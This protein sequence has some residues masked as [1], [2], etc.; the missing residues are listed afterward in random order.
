[1]TVV[2]NIKT[3]MEGK[4]KLLQ[5]DL[6]EHLLGRTSLSANG[7]VRLFNHVGFCALN[8]FPPSKGFYSEGLHFKKMHLFYEFLLKFQLEF[9]CKIIL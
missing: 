7:K 3:I 5:I 9:R 6:I 4:K 8:E 2:A 1:M